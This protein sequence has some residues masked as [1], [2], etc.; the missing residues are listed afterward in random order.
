MQVRVLY[1]GMLRGLAGRE[2]EVVQLSDGAR[3]S[4]L[5][6]EIQQR[7]PKLHDFGNAIALSINYEYADGAAVLHDNDEVA[8]IPPVSGGRS[9]EHTSELQSLR[10]LVC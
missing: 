7:M 3:L 4:D 8:L 6:A 5:Y 10:H 2:R 1:L 9:E